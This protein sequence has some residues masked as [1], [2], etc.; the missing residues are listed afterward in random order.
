MKKVLAITDSYNWATYFR[1]KN[2]KENLKKYNFR[3]ISFHDIKKVNFNDFDIVYVLNWP[4]YG[5]I[6][7]KISKNRKYRLVTGISS[8]IGRKNAKEMKTFFSI[9]DSIGVSNKFLFKEFKNANIKNIVYTPFGVNHNIFKKTTNPNDYKFIF[10]WVGNDKRPVKRYGEICKVFKQ[11]GPKYKLLT[12][13]QGSGFSR[14]KMAKFYNSISAIICYS[15]SEGTPNPVLEAA[16]CGR[17]VISTLVGNVPE[18]MEGVKG[19]RPVNSYKSLLSAVERYGDR[20]DLNNIGSR[21]G[22]AAQDDWTWKIKSKN[23]V[24]LLG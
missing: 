24:R 5:Y 21:V 22:A 9:F 19:F 13:T 12:V 16:M 1:A 23:F 11:L 3:I 14:E 7:H 18:L 20:V 6:R 8:H 15:E 10:G 2:L 4:I 17:P